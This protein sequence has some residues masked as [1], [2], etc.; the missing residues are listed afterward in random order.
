MAEEVRLPFKFEIGQV[1]RLR[2]G[3]PAM[4]VSDRSD[5]GVLVPNYDLWWFRPDGELKKANFVEGLLKETH[6]DA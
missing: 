4:V 2:C 6:A 1:V 5:K 3:G